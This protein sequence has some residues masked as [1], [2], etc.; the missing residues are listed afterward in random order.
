VHYIPE[1]EEILKRFSLEETIFAVPE[2]A[3]LVYDH[4]KLSTVGKVYVF[5]KGTRQVFSET[6]YEKNLG[7]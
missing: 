3:A 1:N 2:G 7:M 5:T 4:G 6:L